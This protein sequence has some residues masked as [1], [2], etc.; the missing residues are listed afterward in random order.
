MEHDRHAAAEIV[1]PED[2][3]PT[4]EDRVTRTKEF[5]ALYE[6]VADPW[7]ISKRAPY[8]ATVWSWILGELRQKPQSAEDVGCGVGSFLHALK[9]VAP[10]VRPSGL[11]YSAR[12]A[13]SAR[14]LTGMKIRIGDIRQAPAFDAGTPCDLVALNDVLT[15]LGDEWRLGLTHCLRFLRPRYAVISWSDS[16]DDWFP[17]YSNEV[18]TWSGGCARLYLVAQHTFD[19]PADLGWVV[20][21]RFALYRVAYGCVGAPTPV[22][23]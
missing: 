15:Y 21:Q 17:A 1:R 20:C 7:N 10:E 19:L 16:P 8:Y 13:E 12:A 6:N 23:G 2:P 5:E 9:R 4:V 3:R 18:Y 22:A 11:E 14:K